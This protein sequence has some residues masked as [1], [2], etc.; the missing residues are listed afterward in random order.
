MTRLRCRWNQAPYIGGLPPP[1]GHFLL[2]RRNFNVSGGQ[3]LSQSYDIE[4][5]PLKNTSPVPAAGHPTRRRWA[6]AARWTCASNGLRSLRLA[7][8]PRRL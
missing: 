2:D 4:P 3:K 5:K 8:T 7:C 1:N 6:A